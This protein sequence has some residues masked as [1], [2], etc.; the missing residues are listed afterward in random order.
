MKLNQSVTMQA[1][2]IR[3]GNAAILGGQRALAAK[4]DA[5]TQRVPG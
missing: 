3:A 1:S 4:D 5:G 2:G